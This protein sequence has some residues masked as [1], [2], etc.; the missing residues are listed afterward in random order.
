[1]TNRSDVME[2]ASFRPTEDQSEV[3]AFLGASAE[4]I[5]THAAHVFLK[6]DL[7]LKLK[8][9][10]KLPYLDFST[11]SLRR[12]AVAQELEINR[13]FAPRLYL[14]IK[15]VIRRSDGTLKLGGRGRTLDWIL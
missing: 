2:Q 12:A 8:K 14:D 15:P 6:G 5:E 11:R 3:L 9:A 13:A 1:M 7:A 10:V 4:Q